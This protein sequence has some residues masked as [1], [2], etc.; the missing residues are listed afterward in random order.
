MIWRL[1][2]EISGFVQ[3]SILRES[4]GMIRSRPVM[5]LYH[6]PW[7]PCA[8]PAARLDLTCPIEEEKTPNYSPERFYPI[9]LGQ[10]LNGRYQ[11]ATKLGYGAN[12]TVWLARDLNRY[13][14]YFKFIRSEI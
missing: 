5:A 9:R 7:P 1:R 13:K 8:I 2:E 11:V 14:F 6:Q 3:I 12:S 10:L 4:Q